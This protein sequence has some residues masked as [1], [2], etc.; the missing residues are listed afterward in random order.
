MRTDLS[1]G[2]RGAG[3]TCAS[4][5]HRRLTLG[6]SESRK[7][8]VRRLADRVRDRRPGETASPIPSAHSQ[9]W[10][11]ARRITVARFMTMTTH[12]RGCESDPS[13]LSS[14]MVAPSNAPWAG[15]SKSP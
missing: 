14:L 8:G 10:S 6:C 9:L 2:L 1:L 7:L 12:L 13:S 15:V 3:V 4:V 5:S 11:D